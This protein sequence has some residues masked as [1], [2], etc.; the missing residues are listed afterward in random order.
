[1]KINNKKGVF[2]SMATLGIF[3][4]AVVVVSILGSPFVCDENGQASEGKA[5]L[6]GEGGKYAIQLRDNKGNPVQYA[7]DINSKH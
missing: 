1:M 2:E 4:G 5:C 3:W 7:A 6:V